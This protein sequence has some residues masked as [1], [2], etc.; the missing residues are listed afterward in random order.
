MS[1]NINEST[2]N[3]FKSEIL[4]NFNLKIYL[5]DLKFCIKDKCDLRFKIVCRN[6]GV[7]F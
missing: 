3:K 2:K 1:E 5:K 6:V 7:F 4:N